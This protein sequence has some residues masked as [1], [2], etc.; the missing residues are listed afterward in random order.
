MIAQKFDGCQLWT[1][2]L[3]PTAIDD[4]N[5][6]MKHN[7]FNSARGL[8]TFGP[9]AVANRDCIKMLKFAI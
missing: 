7:G 3:R 4:I 6:A 1:D 8:I 5:D 2:H 9:T